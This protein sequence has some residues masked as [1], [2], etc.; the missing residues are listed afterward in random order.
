MLNFILMLISLAFGN[1]NANTSS[2]NHDNNG[3]TTTQ[4]TN[5]GGGTDPGDP[6]GSGGNTGGN[7]GQTPPPFTQP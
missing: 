3:Q 7:T 6:P 2:C 5:P 1:N 4:L